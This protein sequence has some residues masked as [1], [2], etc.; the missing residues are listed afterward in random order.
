MSWYDMVPVSQI[1]HRIYVGGYGQA[2]QLAIDN[3]HHISA[4]LD[5]STEPPY[6]ENPNIQYR[7]VPFN[8]GET[9]PR[10]KFAE[11]LGWAK[12]VY[13]A[14][15]VLLVHCA[16]GIS[17]SVVVTASIM[18]YEGIMEFNAALDHIRKCRS[19]ANPAPAV[20]ISAM[21][22]LGVWPYDGSMGSTTT[23]EHEKMI[24]EAFIWMDAYRA[25]QAHTKDNCPMKIFLISHSPEDNTPRHMIECTCEQ[26]ISG[27]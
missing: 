13:E 10:K 26:L 14:G 12:A 19:I 1:T 15:H 9:I 3:P 17:R 25:A 23:A 16:A 4:V 20:K 27:T 2:A 11:C 22:M 7:H 5:V 21:K 6:A 18:H 8:D 24:H